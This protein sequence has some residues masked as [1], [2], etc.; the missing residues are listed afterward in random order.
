MKRK[1]YNLKKEAAN[2]QIGIFWLYKGQILQFAES[3]NNVPPVGGFKDSGYTHDSYWKQVQQMHPELAGKEY[4]DVPRG[5]VLFVINGTYKI[6][7]PS[8]QSK[9]MMLIKRIISNFSLPAA[10]TIV[11]TD[12]HYD[13]PQDADFE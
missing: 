11:E 3:V 13:A 10:K 9:D 7:L 12:L 8:A 5:R 1:V 4:F 6:I 2:P